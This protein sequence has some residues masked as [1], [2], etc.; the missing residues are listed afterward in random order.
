M[1]SCN[2]RLMTAVACISSQSISSHLNE[3][4]TG[5]FWLAS[6]TAKE[7]APAEARM[8]CQELAVGNKTAKR[9]AADIAIRRYRQSSSQ[10]AA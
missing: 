9:S 3:T 7:V 10:P 8:V 2:M 5:N 1:F 6:A 4:L